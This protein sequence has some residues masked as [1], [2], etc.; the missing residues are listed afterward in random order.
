M[1]SNG[2]RKTRTH[3]ATDDIMSVLYHFKQ[4]ISYIVVVNFIGGGH[5]S[6]LRK[7]PTFLKSLYKANMFFF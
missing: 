5:Q 3:I 1:M 2:D 6:T 4:Y 7:H